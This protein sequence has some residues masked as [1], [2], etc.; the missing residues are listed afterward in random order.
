MPGNL[1]H[2]GCIP[3]RAVAVVAELRAGDFASV[4]GLAGEIERIV[5]YGGA[6]DVRIAIRPKSGVLEWRGAN[7]VDSCK[8]LKPP[9]ARRGADPVRL[10]ALVRDRSIQG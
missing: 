3:D 6:F 9:S 8:R 10:H 7:Y 4:A 5:H 2:R 1:R